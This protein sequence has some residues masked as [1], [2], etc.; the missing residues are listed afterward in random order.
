M[1]LP[2]MSSWW[3]WLHRLITGTSNSD[4]DP[5]A[6]EEGAAPAD[7]FCLNWPD[8]D[9][10]CPGWLWEGFKGVIR[11]SA[12]LKSGAA[13]SSSVVDA[14]DAFLRTSSM[15]EYPERLELVRSFAAH[16]AELGE[17][18]R[19]E[20][21]LNL[22]RYYDQFS[23]EITAAREKLKAPIAKSLREEARLGK[24]DEQTYYSLAESAQRTHRK[25]LKFLKSYDDVLQVTR[26][27]PNSSSVPH[28]E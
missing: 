15:G 5:A 13:L 18:G 4:Q 25:L 1:N 11:K 16:C 12:P 20:I 26:P 7:H 22:W 27:S 19:H 23:S 21:L 10:R 9:G 6:G 24:W 2:T 28:Y 17:W 8:L 3:P 14:L